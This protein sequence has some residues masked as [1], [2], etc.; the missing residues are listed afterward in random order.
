MARLGRD[1]DDDT[2]HPYGDYIVYSD[3]G[4]ALRRFP[5]DE[6]GRAQ[7]EA[8]FHEV[9]QLD[10]QKRIIS[11]NQ[12]LI[13][14]QRTQR[15]PQ[16]SRQTPD[17][18]NF[19][20]TPRFPQ[21]SGQIL[22]PEY[23]EWLQFKK[24]TDP[25]FKQWKRQKELEKARLK[26]EQ[27]RIER[28]RI[29]AERRRRQEEEQRKAK[30]EA[31]RKKAEEE[32]RKAE[33]EERRKKAEEEKKA[34]II[35]EQKRKEREELEKKK[36]IFRENEQAVIDGKKSYKGRI[37][38]YQELLTLARSSQNMTVI[39]QLMRSKDIAILQELKKNPLIT[40]KLRTN[41][42]NRIQKIWHIKKH[43]YLGYL[44]DIIDDYEN[45]HPILFIL[46]GLLLFTAVMMSVFFILSL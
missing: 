32:K 35:E 22:D 37:I 28:E 39:K 16:P 40:N 7:A 4:Y 44:F 14:F 15:F 20:K 33:E 25:E 18:F 3:E 1:Y 8:Y 9:Q 31:Q 24:E 10:N 26:A 43:G 12:E 38:T 34:R 6:Q 41:I 29:E 5:D 2:N 23:R 45:N 21:P 19:Q 27:E 11:Q 42:S 17:S 30:E 13:N 36:R 46:F